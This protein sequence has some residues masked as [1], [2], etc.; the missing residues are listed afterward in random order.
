MTGAHIHLIVN[1]VPISGMIFALPLLIAAHWRKSPALAAAGLWAVVAS[2]L[3]AAI[4]YF[5]GEPAEDAVEKLPGISE[6]LIHAHEEAGEK[7]I[8]LVGI[9]AAI[10]LL[11]L[12]LSYRKRAL[13]GWAVP[14]VTAACLASAAILAWTNNLGGQIHHPEIRDEGAAAASAGEHE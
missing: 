7:A 5:S 13:P 3:V 14:T 2:G 11:A 12:F 9:T 1:H 8:V 6:R 4:S 10:A